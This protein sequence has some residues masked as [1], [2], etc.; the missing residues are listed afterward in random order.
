MTLSLVSAQNIDIHSVF[1]PEVA[2][3]VV[4]PI[5]RVFLVTQSLGTKP[6]K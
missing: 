2:V 6:G 1:L 4:C 5:P 3:G